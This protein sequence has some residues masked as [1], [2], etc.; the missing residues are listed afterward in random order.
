RT[1]SYDGAVRIFGTLGHPNMLGAY[2]A[3]TMPLTVW[4]AVRARSG[5]ERILGALVATASGITIAAT[6]SRGAWIGLG[7]GA[8]AVPLL[9]WIGRR[10]PAPSA[11]GARPR[12]R[13]PATVL[14]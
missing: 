10:G 8:I 13:L 9:A 11:G 2:L 6:L 1:A 4:L 7:A 14:V 12:S 5:T 3:M